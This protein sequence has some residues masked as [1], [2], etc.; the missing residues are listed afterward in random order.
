MTKKVLYPTDEI[1]ASEIAR[2]ATHG[3]KGRRAI[4]TRFLGA[5]RWEPDMPARQR[6]ALNEGLIATALAAQADLTTVIRNRP[7]PRSASCHYD[8][9]ARFHLTSGPVTFYFY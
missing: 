2:R 7:V 8:G 6:T 4:V 5:C 3:E 9:Q 1:L